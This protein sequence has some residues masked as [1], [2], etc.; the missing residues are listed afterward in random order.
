MK[1]I[2]TIFLAIILVIGLGY[3]FNSTSP[4]ENLQLSYIQDISFEIPFDANSNSENPK[5]RKSGLHLYPEFSAEIYNP[6]ITDQPTVSISDGEYSPVALMYHA[7][8]EVP[9]TSLDGL[10]LRPSEF[11]DQLK[12][13]NDLGYSYCFADEFQHSDTPSVILTFDDGYT[14]NYTEMF[15]ILK[16]YNAKATIFVFTAAIDGEGYLTRE[17]IQEMSE[18]GLVR[19]ASHS[20]NHNNL[21]PMSEEDIR[22]EF[23]HSKQILAELTGHETNAISYPT[24]KTSDIVIQ[25]AQDYFH[26]GYTTVNSTYTGDCNPLLIP[27]V[28]IYRGMTGK[29]LVARL[30]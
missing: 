8:N 20:H 22:Y 11:E 12:V 10:F 29:G 9:Q 19:F 28:R 13:L 1:H 17:Q 2:L 4:G 25:I 30:G 16:K 3:A 15:P 5:S 14:D 26:F 23:E 6:F 18:S 7:V 24:G 21:T 27:R